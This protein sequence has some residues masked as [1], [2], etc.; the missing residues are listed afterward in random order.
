MK[1]GVNPDNRFIESILLIKISTMP[2]SDVVKTST[3]T[4][5]MSATIASSNLSPYFSKY[6][7][8]YSPFCAERT[9]ALTEYPRSSSVRTVHIATKPFAPVTR[10]C[11]I[12]W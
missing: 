4:C 12:R 3:H 11:K 7:T 1:D 2:D 10:T 5:V 6:R 9:V 8:R